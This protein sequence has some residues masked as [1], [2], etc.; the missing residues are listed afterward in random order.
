MI[1]KPET[2]AREVLSRL[3][4]RGLME[5]RGVGKGRDYHLSASVYRQVGDKA[6]YVRQ[7][8]FEP[9]QQEQMILQY[10]E[11][12]G[13]ITRGEAAKLCRLSPDQAYRR[14]Q[15]LLESNQVEKHGSVRSAWYT[16]RA[17]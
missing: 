15:K 11:K 16:R 6:G 14:L 8:G 4:E 3:V 7:R 17:K 9:L 12:H 1:Q 5:A 13:R 2:E 10:L